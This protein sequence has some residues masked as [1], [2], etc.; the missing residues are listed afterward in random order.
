MPGSHGMLLAE[1]ISAQC[2][3]H[4]LAEF[5]GDLVGKVQKR[6]KV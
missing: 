4:S 6:K 5:L 1:G 2:W 3:N